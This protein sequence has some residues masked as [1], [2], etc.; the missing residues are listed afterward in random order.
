MVSKGML[1]LLGPAFT[2]EVVSASDRSTRV[3]RNL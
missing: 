1:H 2:D 3:L